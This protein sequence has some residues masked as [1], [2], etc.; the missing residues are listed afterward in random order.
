MKKFLAINN[1]TTLQDSKLI[2]RMEKLLEIKNKTKLQDLKPKTRMEKS[3]AINSKTTLQNSKL[4]AIIGKLLATLYLQL[5]LQLQ[6]QTAHVFLVELELKIWWNQNWNFTACCT[7]KT[8]GPPQD[9]FCSLLSSSLLSWC[10]LIN[11]PTT[12]IMIFFFIKNF[13]I[14]ETIWQIKF[15]NNCLEIQRFQLHSLEVRLKT[16]PSQ[17]QKHQNNT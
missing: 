14:V 8:N 4:I 17:N 7:I 1:I 5:Q 6:H 15:N 2:T 12:L 3:L 16:L 13:W 10:K 9:L 11:Q